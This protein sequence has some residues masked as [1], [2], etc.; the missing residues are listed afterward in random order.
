MRPCTVVHTRTN[1][2]LPNM[3][4]N[5]LR[6]SKQ[7][8]VFITSAPSLWSNVDLLRSNRQPVVKPQ[9]IRSC[10]R[11]SQYKIH[12]ARLHKYS[13]RSGL[14]ALATTCK[15]LA[16]LEFLQTEFGGDSIIETVM[17]AR[18]LKVLKL[19]VAVELSLDQISLIL[20]HRPTLAHLQADH[21][22]E[23]RLQTDWQV[24]LPNLQV[25]NLSVTKD[26]VVSG[27]STLGY[28]NC[29]RRLHTTLQFR[30]AC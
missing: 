21:V 9:F 11:H 22:K 30:K 25:F 10:I 16:N 23:P 14:R 18:N 2:G 26:A 27:A 28:L 4:R 6:V 15:H 3:C 12:T 19:S 29:V 13:D 17:I 5:C 20:K 8:N 24:D 1:P 7:W